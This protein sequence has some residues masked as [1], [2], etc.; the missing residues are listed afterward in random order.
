MGIQGF[1]SYILENKERFVK[2][3]DLTQ[4]A[5]QQNGVEILVDY[6]ACCNLFYEKFIE[7]TGNKSILILGGNYDTFY[8][9]VITFIKKMLSVNIRLT[10][11]ADGSRGS[12]KETVERKMSTWLSRD[13]SDLEKMRNIRNAFYQYED[14]EYLSSE[15]VTRPVLFD[16]VFISAL[17]ECG[18]KVTFY[19]GEADVEIAKQ[20]LDTNA[21]AILSNDSDFCI[22]KN[23]RYIPM[24]LFDLHNDLQPRQNEHSERTL[25]RLEIGVIE[26]ERV[27]D[28]LG[29]SH[30]QLIEM[31]IVA[32]NDITQHFMKYNQN[33]LYKLDVQEKKTSI[34]NI[35]D[36]VKCYKAVENHPLLQEEMRQNSAF[37]RA[38]H[39]S[40]RFFR[41]EMNE[42]R[43]R[44]ALTELIVERIEA[45]TLHQKLASLINGIYWPKTVFEDIDR[46]WPGIENLLTDLRS[47]VY[48]MLLSSDEQSVIEYGRDKYLK[49]KPHIVPAAKWRWLPRLAD[50]KKEDVHQNLRIF[51]RII[52]QQESGWGTH[53]FIKRYGRRTGFIFACL[54]YF[55]LLNWRRNL[56]VSEGEFLALLCLLF[57]KKEEQ[58][59]LSYFL[60]PPL[61]CIII[62]NWMQDIY[63]HAYN[64]IGSTLFIRDEFPKP[65][66]LFSGSTW[67][68]FYLSFCSEI[69]PSR[70]DTHHR[71]LFE[72]TRHKM[73]DIIYEKR[74]MIKCLV[75]G[76]FEF[77]T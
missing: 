16:S 67:V 45:G 30:D 27:C 55:L 34:Q 26:T 75:D 40:R 31:S 32:G 57:T 28:M 1:N 56:F 21:F 13:R 39:N 15:K 53:D 48:R 36:W 51:H 29:L 69:T 5:E 18:C 64:Y 61:R 42:D 76:V 73:N 65:H 7:T 23:C 17:K 14:I 77:N 62:N 24:K 3:T 72:D 59:Y 52:S 44:G 10:F 6:Y 71:R 47:C 19:M 70:L 22:F 12:C 9:Y 8:H 58:K 43:D 11:L 66:T 49:I 25:R 74:H 50:I 35:V 46:N 63:H 68:I 54:R 38:V 37:A 4:V 2:Y 41:L 20:L 33:L 60:N